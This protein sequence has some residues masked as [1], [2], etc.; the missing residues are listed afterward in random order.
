LGLSRAV[1]GLSVKAVVNPLI[2]VVLIS[3]VLILGWGLLS[4]TVNYLSVVRLEQQLHSFVN[5]ISSDT[6]FYIEALSSS[7]SVYTVYVGLLRVS[8]IPTVYYLCVLNQSNNMPVE[9]VAVEILYDEG[10]RDANSMMVES[11]NMYVLSQIARYMPLSAET[12]V[13]NVTLYIINFTGQEP[14]SIKINVRVEAV[15]Q[16]PKLTLI[17][18]VPY[19]QKYYEVKRLYVDWGRW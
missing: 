1:K 6:H 7:E 8:G 12:G 17:L 11:D 15:D 5:E 16:Q 4:M 19:G 2:V 13:R 3:V 10:Y 9:N 18:L 14:L